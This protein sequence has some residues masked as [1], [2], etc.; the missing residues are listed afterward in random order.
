MLFSKKEF[1][2]G[3]SF[4]AKLKFCAMVQI[5]RI[6][7]IASAHRTPFLTGTAFDADSGEL[8]DVSRINRPHRTDGGAVSAVNAF[9]GIDLRFNLQDVDWGALPVTGRIIRPNGITALYLDRMGQI[10]RSA[11]PAR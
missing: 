1:R 6:V 2:L 11:H 8:C 9:I 10:L 5:S 3:T 4:I 7:K